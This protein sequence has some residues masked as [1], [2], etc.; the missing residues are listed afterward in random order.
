M[1]IQTERRRWQYWGRVQGVGFRATVRRLATGFPVTGSVRNLPDG[2]VEVEG[3]GAPTDLDRFER[4]I[5]LEFRA[6]I[7]DRRS[8]QAPAD[9]PIPDDFTIQA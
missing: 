3:F 5:E 2:S 1:A 8:E 4:A 9:A 7:H 6:N